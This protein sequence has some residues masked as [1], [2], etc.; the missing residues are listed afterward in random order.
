M[1]NGLGT[2]LRVFDTIAERINTHLSDRVEWMSFEEIM[3]Y[4]IDNRESF[5]K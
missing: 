2:G 5:L 1:S 4:V 3:N